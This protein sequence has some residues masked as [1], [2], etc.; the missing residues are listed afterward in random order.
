MKEEVIEE[1]PATEQQSPSEEVEEPAS[2]EESAQTPGFTSLFAIALIAGAA[3]V[4]RR[5]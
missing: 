4:M 2:E 5:D 3:L 1:E